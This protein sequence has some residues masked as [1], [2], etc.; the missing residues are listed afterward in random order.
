MAAIGS[1][2]GLGNIWRF[3]YTVA[4]NGG[5]AFLIPYLIALLTAGIPILILEF[6][7]GHKIRNGAP[8]VFGKLNKKW[9]VLGWWQTGISFAITTYYTAVI[10][11]SMSYFFFSFNLDW[12]GDPK[13]F[14]FGDYLRLTD[15]PMTFGGINFKVAIPLVIVWA[16]NYIVPAFGIKKGI[17][18]ANKILMPMLIMSLLIMVVRGVTLPGALE[19]LNY[20]FKPN[21]AM[22]ANGKVWLAAYGQVFYSLSIAFGI[23]LAYSSYLPKKSD[24]VNNAFIT[25]FGNC[26]FS[27]LSGIAVFS[28]LG[29][30]ANSQGVPVKDVASAGVGLAFIV[31]PKA[32]NALPGM[33]NLFAVMF[34]GSLVF[35][36]ISSSISLVET[37]TSSIVDRFGI[38]RI[39]ALTLSCGTGLV[40]SLLFATGA[41]LYILDIADYYI[42]NYAIAISGLIEIVLLAWFFNLESVRSYVNPLSDFQVGKWWNICIKYLTPTLLGVMTVLN[43]KTDILA[44]YEGYPIEALLKYGA[45]F[46]V[47]SF[48]LGVIML[49]LRASRYSAGELKEVM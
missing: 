6:G 48:I 8:G 46:V 17:E 12:G 20:Y 34:F 41:G 45:G 43:I 22:L 16:I 14:L 39:K 7:L 13:T 47:G 31:F 28:I 38:S 26:S 27:L 11:W 18:K 24:I 29:Y 5:G 42:N 3:P 23:M 9:E 40:V 33:N 1:A 44:P 19:G 35:A 25:G 2:I 15:S 49:K 4:S 10:A 32:I 37:F 36:G 21:F 30:M